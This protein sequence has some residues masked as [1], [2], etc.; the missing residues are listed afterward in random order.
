MRN[1][2]FCIEIDC[3][4]PF[5]INA[6]KYDPGMTQSPISTIAHYVCD[7]DAQFEPLSAM[8]LGT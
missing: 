8:I 4:S 2:R 7:R 5:G 6:S 3:N 1:F